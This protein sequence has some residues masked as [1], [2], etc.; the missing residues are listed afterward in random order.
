[1]AKEKTEAPARPKQGRLISDPVVEEIEDAAEYY[2]EVRNNRMRLTEQEV[3]ARDALASVLRKHRRTTYSGQKWLVELTN[4]VGV[5]V[6]SATD[7]NGE[8]EE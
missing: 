3:T 1:M 4:K 5:K 6:K 7:D 2:V 8:P